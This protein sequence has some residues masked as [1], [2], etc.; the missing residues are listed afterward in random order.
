MSGLTF[1]RPERALDHGELHLARLWSVA[2]MVAMI[3]SVIMIMVVMVT[4]VSVM[5][6]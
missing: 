1:I 2:V 6:P 5:V 3:V 4:T